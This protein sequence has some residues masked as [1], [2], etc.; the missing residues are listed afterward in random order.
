MT[1]GMTNVK[2]LL[3][4]HVIEVHCTRRIDS[5]AIHTRHRLGK[6]YSFLLARPT[7]L[8]AS[9]C[10]LIASI[11]ELRNSLNLSLLHSFRLLSS[12]VQQLDFLRCYRCNRSN[13]Y[14]FR[15]SVNLR[16]QALQTFVDLQGFTPFVT[17]NRQQPLFFYSTY[18]YRL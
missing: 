12:I 6:G 8:V 18:V 10:E 17:A 11:Q 15:H 7:T 2:L 13:C 3:P 5:A 14:R 4:I 1:T 16:L 9:V